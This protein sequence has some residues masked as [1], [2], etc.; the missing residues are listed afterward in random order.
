MDRQI[1]PK[2]LN[3]PNYKK[4]YTD[5]I[6]RKYP[7]KE[8]VCRSI[9]EKKDFSTLD[10]LAIE[11]LLFVKQKEK[12]SFNQKHRFYDLETIK[13]ILEYQQ[14]KNLNNTELASHFKLSRNT[15]TNWKKNFYKN[16]K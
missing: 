16:I 5:M 6:I 13:E 7:E 3:R 4:I 8:S 1:Q 10:V 14:Q 2:G 12:A 11:K 15:V 9:L